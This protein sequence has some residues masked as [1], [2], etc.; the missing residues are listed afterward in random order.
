[1]RRSYQL[2]KMKNMRHG[3]LINEADKCPSRS[4]WYSCLLDHLLDISIIISYS[5][6]AVFNPL[7]VTIREETF[8]WGGRGG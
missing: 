4:L 2:L 7:A 6:S 1:M 3:S 8:L 5:S